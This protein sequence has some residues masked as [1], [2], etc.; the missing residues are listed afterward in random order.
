MNLPNQTTGIH[1]YHIIQ[2]FEY[3]MF[4]GTSFFLSVML[5]LLDHLTW[6]ESPWVHFTDES[7]WIQSLSILFLIFMCLIFEHAESAVFHSRPLIQ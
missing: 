7:S 3:H 1:I 4:V 6:N 2:H 5:S